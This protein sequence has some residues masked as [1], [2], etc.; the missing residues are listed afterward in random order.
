MT[1]L[2]WRTDCARGVFRRPDAP[3]PTHRVATTPLRTETNRCGACSEEMCTALGDSVEEL[4]G[5]ANALEQERD[6]LRS[7]NEVLRDRLATLETDRARLRAEWDGVQAEKLHLA[8]S[9]LKAEKAALARK[10]QVKGALEKICEAAGDAVA[11]D[12]GGVGSREAIRNIVGTLITPSR[13]GA[14]DTEEMRMERE[15]DVISTLT[16]LARDLTKNGVN[17]KGYRQAQN[18][19]WATKAD[20]AALSSLL[21]TGDAPMVRV[22]EVQ[23]PAGERVQVAEVIDVAV[24][25]KDLRVKMHSDKLVASPSR[26]LASAVFQACSDIQA[27]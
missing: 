14:G 27:L 24:V 18:A 25:C 4:S 5:R 1:P 6:A 21:G 15:M 10:V 22:S 12:G 11:G 17:V 13:P 19:D 16:D 20:R 7:D 9:A 3:S 26:W 2:A 8:T 23:G